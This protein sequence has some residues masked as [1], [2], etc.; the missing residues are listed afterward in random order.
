MGRG[1][2]V[3]IPNDYAKYQAEG[4][5]GT[6][7][8]PLGWSSQRDGDLFYYKYDKATSSQTF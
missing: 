5:E 1:T 2:L 3:K 4:L 6:V 8:L 7:A